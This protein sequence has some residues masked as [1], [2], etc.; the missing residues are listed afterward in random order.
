MKKYVID[1]NVAAKWLYKESL[2]KEAQR[3]LIT[4]GK[5]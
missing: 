2:E 4:P 3:Y 1:A 5:Q